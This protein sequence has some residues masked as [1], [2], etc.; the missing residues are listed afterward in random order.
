MTLDAPPSTDAAVDR[1]L[2]DI[3]GALAAL[4]AG[5]FSVRLEPRSGAAG[6]IADRVNELAGLHERRTRELVRASRVIGREG[7]MTERLDEVGVEG[8]WSTASAAVNSLIDDLVRPTT[9][10]ARVIAAVAEGDLSQHMALE[11]AGQPVKGEFLR[12]GATVNTMVDQLS[13]FADEVTRVAREVGTEGK[14]GGQAQ[15]RGVSGVWRDLTESVNSMAGN[16]TSQ[17]RNIAQVTTAVAR[18]DLSQKITVDARGEILELKSTVNTM[19][20]Q[21]SSFADEVTRVA[22]EVGTEGRLGGQAQVR[23]VSGTWRDLTD[24]VN[25]MAVNL[26]NQVRGIAQVAT[27]VARGDLSQK[28][29]VDAKGE[30]A[31]LAGTINTMVDQLSSFADEVTRVAR[32]VGTEGKLGGQADVPGVAGTWKDLTD[33]VN[34]MAGNLT[35]QVRNIA[36]IVTAVSR[37]DLTQKITVDAAGEV[38]A[39]AETINDL[40]DTLQVFAQQ[41]TTVAREVGTEGKLGGQADVPGV[42][43]TWK[44]LTDNVNGM[45]ANLTAQVRDIAQVTTAVAQGDLSQKVSVDVRGETLELKST[46]NTMVD[47]LSSFADEVTRVAREVGTEGKLGGQ[48]QVK[49]VSGT[50]K[51]LTDNVN[52]MAGNLTSQVRNIAQVATAVAKGDLSQKITVDARGEILELKD[53]VNTM[54]DQLSSFADEVTR[55]AREVGTE[56]KLGGQAQVKGVSGTWK[57]LTDNVNGMAGNLTSQVRNIA[58]V[59]TAVAKGDLSQKITVDAKGE[60]AALAQTINTMVDQLSSFADEVTRVAREVGTEGRLGGQAQV[61]GVSGTWRDLTDNVNFM[62]ANLTGQV[63]N[64]A[65]VATAVARGDLSQKITVNAQGEILDLKNVVNTMVDQLSS[66]ADEVT[67]VAREVGTEGRLGGQAQVKG[68]SG[69]WRDLTDNVN[70]MASNLTS[71]VRNI[72][73]VTTAVAQ[74]DLSQKITVDAQ[75]EILDLKSTVNTM[76]DQLSAFAAEVTR[77]AREVGTEGK[78]GGQ[79]E[80]AGVSGTW[81]HLTEN[82]NQLAGNLTTQVRAIAEVSTAV[83]RGDLTRSITVEAQGEVAEL[84]DNINQMIANLRATTE[85]NAQQDWLKSNLARI[86]GQLQ[87]QRDLSAV[88]QLIM[89]EVTPVVEAVQGAFFLAEHDEVGRARLRR[90]ASYGSG[91]SDE[92]AFALGEGLIGQAA[93]DKRP[94]RVRDVPAGYLRVRSGLGEGVPAELV[95]LPVL[96]EEEVLGVI[97]LASFRRYDDVHATFLEQL[98]ETIGVVLNTI[99]ANARTEALLDQSQR[100]AQELREQ[101][102]ELQRTNAELEDKA[103]L[104]TEQ[105]RD[106]E[107]KNREIELARTGLEEKA[108]Q[109]ALSSQYKSEFLANMSHELRTPLNSLLI[110]AKLLADN[111]QRNLTDKQIEFARTIHGSGSDLLALINDILD[112]SKVEAGKMDVNPAPVVLRE[113]VEHV[114]SAFGP[115]AEQ[116]GLDLVVEVEPGLPAALI[117]DE[118]RLHQVLKNLLSNALK[119]TERGSVRLSVGT[120][121]PGVLFS[122]PSLNDAE[123]VLAFRVADTGI[124]VPA[125]KLRLIFEAF[126][127]ADGTTSRKYGGTGLGLSISRE[128]ARLLGGAITVESESGRGSTF[129]LYV[130]ATY[131]FAGEGENPGGPALPEQATPAAPPLIT[132][133][134]ASHDLEGLA[135]LTVLVVDDD[136][137]NVFA[138]TSALELHGMRVLYADNGKSGLA[139]LQEHPEIDLVLMDVMMPDM[140]GNETTRVLRSM[141]AFADLPVLFLTAKAMPGDRDKSLAAGASD[142]ITK[143]VDLDRLLSLIATWTGREQTAGPGV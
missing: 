28:I 105:S 3:A 6:L 22:R 54:V 64:I 41:V 111:P 81:R 69:T 11:I 62:A 4:C 14:L 19:V 38:A 143:P 124:G 136:V 122:V 52:G 114:Q 138:L 101:S 89:S 139:L 125:E 98:V 30:V 83:T 10:V 96:F 110:L 133:R 102:V 47:Q 91:R 5:D 112:L 71:Q 42:A 123:Q 79:A 27:A 65:Q 93:L 99:I 76:V 68:I 104:L 115:L 2:A 88:T 73:L 116:Q 103:R 46:I 67:R 85:K 23:D 141:P 18:G 57:D 31:A 35:S 33:S 63:R 130:P 70:F 107:A 9:E 72:A 17:V 7:R 95:V 13:S 50:W 58:Q 80:V 59:T 135:G 1:D 142:Y 90:A 60:V 53:V 29:T 119:F 134:P 106:L 49:G 40:T 109:L 113:V 51:D 75:G 118:Q 97:E 24:S 82:V 92:D 55:V 127:Q 126:Q 16:L 131:P 20:D 44:D 94:L 117:T 21:L 45:A 120:P 121:P 78:L 100:L 34:S 56:G 128:I 84:K 87:G 36:Q 132:A 12:I 25:S 43:G 74:G 15:V 137:R 39:L 108:E 77:V 86:G 66:F 140:D 37:G 26:T 32:E 129:T 48:A 8:D 61:K